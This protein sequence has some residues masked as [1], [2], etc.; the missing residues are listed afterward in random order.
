MK[1]VEIRKPA[2]EYLNG[3]A[4]N[5]QIVVQTDS[6]ALSDR[7][8]KASATVAERSGPTRAPWPE[9]VRNGGASSRS[10]HGKASTT[11]E[12]VAT[13]VTYCLSL[14]P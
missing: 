5:V 12:S 10:H 8:V 11:T 13:T 4:Q 9:V 6:A 3:I 14:V 2:C 7:P 1:A